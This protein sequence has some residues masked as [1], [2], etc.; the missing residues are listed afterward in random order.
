MM[1]G[2]LTVELIGGNADV[3]IMCGQLAAILKETVSVPAVAL[4]SNMACR[5]EPAPLSLV[6]TTV[7][8]AAS[9]GDAASNDQPSPDTSAVSKIRFGN[10]DCIFISMIKVYHARP[11]GYSLPGHLRPFLGTLSRAEGV[12]PDLLLY[13]ISAAHLAGSVS[14]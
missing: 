1:T 9:A 13:S 14:V 6:L 5:S 2:E 12:L 8:V 4:A 3:G 7:K 10:R 11:G